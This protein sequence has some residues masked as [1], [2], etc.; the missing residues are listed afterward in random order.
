MGL[1]FL[2][3]TGLRKAAYVLREKPEKS[4]TSYLVSLRSILFW[5]CVRLLKG[6]KIFVSKFGCEIP[7]GFGEIKVYTFGIGYFNGQGHEVKNFEMEPEVRGTS[8]WV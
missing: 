8:C 4:M 5:L 7:R 3:K 2:H 1:H 6:C